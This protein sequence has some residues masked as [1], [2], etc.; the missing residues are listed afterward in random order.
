MLQAG[1]SA[2]N[3]PI[4]EEPRALSEGPQL[5]A[6][7]TGT[8]LTP[9]HPIAPPVY[10]SL[11]I[12]AHDEEERIGATL[13]RVLEY[14]SGR[15]YSWEVVVVD[16]VSSDGTA[17]VVSRFQQQEARL[18][19]LHRAA[20]PGKGAAVQAGMFA[21]KGQRVLF[22]D[23]DLSTPIEESE[24]LLD[25]VEREGYDIAIGSRG[26]PQSDLR[27]RQ[28]WYRETMGRVFNLM[29]RA[30]ALRGFKDTQC[31]F[32]LFR[33]EVAADLF[34]RQTIMG[35]A[36]DVEI[37]YVAIKRGLRVKEVPVTWINAPR[38]KVDPI[39][40]SLRMARDMMGIR[41]KSLLGLYR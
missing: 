40:D 9:A 29:V 36:F 13:E 4:P 41:F 16:D 2:L 34:G 1:Q 27:V 31:G 37:L 3:N 10:L 6:P 26:L 17:E 23:A 24:K 38:S 7:S 12:P 35:F 14:L 19:L 22:S 20:D 11:V 18:R 8:R 30:V 33:G 5:L 28:P 15:E 39:R 21:A 32:K 25:A